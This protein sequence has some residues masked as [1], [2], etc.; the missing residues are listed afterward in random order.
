MRKIIL[1]TNILL[2]QPRILGLEIP[3]TEFLIPLDVI[4]ELNIRAQNRGAKFDRRIDLIEK[5]N[6]QG[7]ITIIN[8]DSPTIQQYRKLLKSNKLSGTDL[9][10][11]AIYNPI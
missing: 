5:A 8:V 7:T 1:D 11:I 4:E 2:R 6:L 10:I 9:S 3:N